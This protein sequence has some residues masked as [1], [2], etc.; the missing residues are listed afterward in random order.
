MANVPT[1]NY[2]ADAAG[3]ICGYRIAPNAATRSVDSEAAAAWLL[4]PADA[5]GGFLWLHFNLAHTGARPW[6]QPISG[7]L[8]W[9]WPCS[10]WSAWQAS[11]A[12]SQ[13]MVQRSVGIEWR[14]DSRSSF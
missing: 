6:R 9:S 14:A 13:M 7:W 11:G 5:E 1:S 4:A 12:L 3:L 10:R 8:S 2:G